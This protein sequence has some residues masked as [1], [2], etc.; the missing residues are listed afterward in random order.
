VAPEVKPI[1]P[2]TVMSYRDD[3]DRYILPALGQLRLSQLDAATL[4]TFYARLRA[5]GGKNSQPLS[6]SK[7]REDFYRDL[8]AKALARPRA[9]LFSDE[10]TRAEL[11]TDA[12]P[13]LLARALELSSVG[14]ASLTAL[15]QAV[16]GLA[17]SYP[18]TPPMSSLVLCCALPGRGAP[19]ACLPAGRLPPGQCHSSAQQHT[20]RQDWRAQRHEQRRRRASSDRPGA[21]QRHQQRQDRRTGQRDQRQPPPHSANGQRPGAASGDDLA[22]IRA[23]IAA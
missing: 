11:A 15:E 22:R 19:I 9:E 14:E 18:S 12:E 21:G 6:A 2:T 7:V 1:S 23:I 4:D 17:R 8:L 13:W 16:G 20:G 3:L 5:A 10:A